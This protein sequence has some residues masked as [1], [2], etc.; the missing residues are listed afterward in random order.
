MVRATARRAGRRELKQ[1]LAPAIAVILYPQPATS[2]D[3]AARR[4]VDRGHRPWILVTPP[5]HRL[6]AQTFNPLVLH[7]GE[8]LNPAI[9]CKV[10]AVRV[11]AHAV[12]AFAKAR[13]AKH[14]LRPAGAD[15]DIIPAQGHTSAVAAGV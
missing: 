8:R 13:H 9:K 7:L 14:D 6:K 15:V 5:V 10:L 11:A 3:V 12:I 4:S 2:A 1:R